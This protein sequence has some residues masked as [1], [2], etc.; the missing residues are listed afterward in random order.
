MKTATELSEYGYVVPY[1]YVFAV[2]VDHNDL[3]IFLSIFERAVF[4]ESRFALIVYKLSY[5]RHT[6]KLKVL[7]D[8]F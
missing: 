5:M 1:D 2:P 6:K 3:K 7:L 8:L 4:S